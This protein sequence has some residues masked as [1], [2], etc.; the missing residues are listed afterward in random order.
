MT[1]IAIATCADEA[2]L[3]YDE[4]PLVDYLQKQG[5]CLYPVIWN[6]PE[7]D[8]T[9]YDLVV[10]RNTWDY[11]HQISAFR[12]WL[13]YLER[14]HIPI[15]NPLALVRWNIEKSYLQQLADQGIATLPTIFAKGQSINLLETLKNRAWDRAVVKPIISGSGDNTWIISS[16]NAE[17]SQHQFDWLNDT[18]GM[19]VQPLASQIRSDGEYSLVFFGGIFSHAVRKKPADDHFLVH[20]ERG[21]TIERIAADESLIQQAQQAL[22]ITQQ[23]TGIMPTYARVDGFIDEGHFVLMELECIEPELYFTRADD[24]AERFGKAIL[25]ALQ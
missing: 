15:L 21:G 10:I 9:S 19:M 7:I 1:L 12:A 8:W 2:N 18:I 20:E 6:S 5:M 22:R 3:F 4:A 25:K 11:H 16:D 24:A 13:D 23:L 14:H 17:K